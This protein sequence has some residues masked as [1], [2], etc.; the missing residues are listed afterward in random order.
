MHEP[1]EW[2]PPVLTSFEWSDPPLWVG[3]GQLVNAPGYCWGATAVELLAAPG[4]VAD[5]R[6]SDIT[7]EYW[8]LA[9]RIIRSLRPWQNAG[10]LELRYIWGEPPGRL[11][12]L[13][14]GRALGATAETARSWASH[15]LDSVTRQ[16]P[17]AYQFGPLAA[18]VPEGID[19]W[20]EIERAEETR[21]PGPF[22]P[23]EA[24]SYYYLIH[25]LTGDGTAWPELPKLLTR[26]QSPGFLSLALVPT[27][28]TDNERSAIDHIN[29][30]ARHLAEP[31]PGYDFFGNQTTTPA[32]A[33]ARDVHLAWERYNAQD[34]V[35]ARI[36]LAGS[37][38][39]LPQIAAGV[40]GILT[41]QA[42]RST[43]DLINRFKIVSDIGDYES[44]QTAT[45]GLV[46][47]R[48]R[49]QVWSLPD[50]QAPVPV[51]RMPYFFTEAE[52]AGLLVLPIPDRDGVPGLLRSRRVSMSRQSV[53]P[54]SA[55]AG[56]RLGAALHHG[57]SGSPIDLPL[58]S[59]NRHVLVVGA[60]G[61]GKTSTVLT[62]L[63]RQW[64]DHGI[65]F[66]VLESVKTEYRS[67]L[68]LAGME[69]LRVI[70][71]GNERL[72]PL[73]LNPLAPP[74][75]VRCEVHKGAVLA[76]LKLAIPLFPPLP[77]ILTK[78][79]SRT[80]AE[81]GWQDDTVIEDGLIPPTL[82]D[83]L[84]NFES[85]F[86]AVGYEGEAK[87]IGLA[88]QVRL[89]SL[90]EG[91]RGK[92][93][94]TVTSVDFDELLRSPAVIEMNDIMDGDDRAVIAAF[95]LDRIRA[96]ARVRGS[97]GGCLRHVTV[98]EEAHRLLARS[99]QQAGDAASG[100]RARADSVRAF[101]EA[102][103][104]LRSS[105]EG[106]VLSSQSPSALAEAAIA[107]TGT[108]ILH[109]LESAADRIVMLDDVGASEWLRDAA[110]ALAVGE[111]IMRWP[112]R[113]EAELVII[114]PDPDIDS[115]RPVDDDTVR[116]AMQGHR[117]AVSRLLPYRLCAEEVCPNGCLSQI[118]SR[119]GYIAEDL[120]VSAEQVWSQARSNRRDALP[121]LAP[122]VAAE[123]GGDFQAAY[124]TAV[125][126]SL[127]GSA[128]RLRPH[129]DDRPRL[130]LAIRE[131]VD[132]ERGRDA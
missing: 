47:P 33:S 57:Q 99:N 83:L 29:T 72:A 97:S 55:S 6:V 35:L 21:R 62:L 86:R 24:A 46:I 119:A 69:E 68:G 126:L 45:M 4:L 26:A 50:D 42:G 129:V 110:G 93:L 56:V 65:P 8:Q 16:L 10:G 113:D 15:M 23:P 53:V 84:R 80:Y 117:Q 105:G 77:Q 25:P 91:S 101:C 70:T 71:L 30:L 108:R 37:S 2:Y 73:R 130:G 60:P 43:G 36:G 120:A 103:A 34:G 109:R 38:D 40:A 58:A 100:D 124:C 89:E 59:I 114:Q 94:D 32:D 17:A 75:R 92:L 118:R 81:A 125:H 27:V 7:S 115:G 76:A 11:R 104:E 5:G 128:F 20:V 79:L 122:L 78:A 123:A 67:L 132:R 98:I 1:A 39:E 22:V 85:V 82:R 31:Q 106:F 64:R 18:S 121:E 13:L 63:L 44:W 14:I 48:G 96:A 3:D 107:N 54:P 9:G 28:M 102:I 87:N 19:T 116:T 52:A 88:F 61:S 131:A 90:L 41:Q 112:E 111:A 127:Q 49:H 95:I 74:A 51:E 66:L 12:V